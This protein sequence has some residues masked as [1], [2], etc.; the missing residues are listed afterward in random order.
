MTGVL[1][2][3]P[4][5]IAYLDDAIIFSRMAEEHL[6]HIREVFEKLWNADL[7]M[8]LSKCH[9]FAKEIQSFDISSA[10]QALHHYR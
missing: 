6:H 3:F 7:S 10:P 2:D 9:F 1:K 4:F 8:R 5:T